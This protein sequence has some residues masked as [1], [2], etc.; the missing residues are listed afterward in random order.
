MDG[1]RAMREVTAAGVPAGGWLL[2]VREP[3]EWAAGHVP[4]AVHIPMGEL[5][6]RVHEVPGD[7]AVYVICRSGV[8]SAAVAQAL[9]GAGWDALNVADGMQG[10][11]AAGRPMASVAGKPYVA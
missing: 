2:D 1:E 9:I 11:A 8:R 6:A 5:A 4:H 3:E 10:W 7:Q